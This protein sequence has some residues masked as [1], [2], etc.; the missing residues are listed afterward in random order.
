MTYVFIHGLGQTPSS[1]DEVIAHLPTDIPIYRPCLSAIVK[2]K[3]ITYE[4]LYKAFE[5]ECNRMEM[6]LCLCGLSLGAVLAL[7][8]TLHNPQKVKSFMLIAPQY[9]MPRLLLGIQNIAFHLDRKST[10]LNSSHSRASRM[11]SSA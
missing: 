2:D 9:K 6:P 5:N 1:W 4:N 11:P 3:Q 8:Y 10:R 7:Q